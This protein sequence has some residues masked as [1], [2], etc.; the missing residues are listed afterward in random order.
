MKK[1]EQKNKNKEE[2]EV[3][4]EIVCDSWS[5]RLQFDRVSY[6]NV[7]FVVYT[8]FV[9][10]LLLVRLIVLMFSNGHTRLIKSNISTK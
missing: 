9:A 4:K 3:D 6:E 8:F 5:I 1:T 2:V 7:L 10:Q